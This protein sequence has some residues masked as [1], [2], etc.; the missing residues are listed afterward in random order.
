MFPYGELTSIDVKEV[1]DHVCQH[2]VVEEINCSD[3][4]P[5][6]L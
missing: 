6:P 3:K 2:S 4:I 1:N 5:I